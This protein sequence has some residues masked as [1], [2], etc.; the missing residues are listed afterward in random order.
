MRGVDEAVT[1][2][3]LL[4]LRPGSEPASESVDATRF[5][6]KGVGLLRLLQEGWPVPEGFVLSTG[7]CR[8]WLSANGVWPVAVRELVEAGLAGLPTGAWP[9]GT[10][11][12]V[13]SGAGR[14]YP[15]LLRT[16][17]RVGTD[18]DAVLAAIAE[19]CDSVRSWEV[20]QAG[21]WPGS[22][23]PT[24]TA[25]VIQRQIDTDCA[26]VLFTVDPRRP[27][28]LLVEAVPGLGDQ[29]VAG[30]GH[31][32]AWRVERPAVGDTG[33]RDTT[34]STT[35]PS[36]A[37][38]QSPSPGSA[39]AP[40]AA[41]TAVPT[42]A[43][44][45]AAAGE[46]VASRRLAGAE[47]LAAHAVQSP[48][49][50]VGEVLHSFARHT[51][52]ELCQAGLAIERHWGGPVD[53]EWGVA[54]SQLWLFQVR[55]VE[56]LVT[57]TSEPQLEAQVTARLAE[58]G[59]TGRRVWIRHN[60]AESLPNPTPLS[61]D[62][63]QRF[64]RPDGGYGAL[65]RSLGYRPAV[66]GGRS[67]IELLG[68]GVYFSADD[69]PGWFCRGFPL[70]VAVDPQRT[71]APLLET[72]PLEFDPTQLDRWFLVRWPWVA[73]V[74]RRARRRQTDWESTVKSE[75]ARTELPG[76][77]AWLR[78]QSTQDLHQM[79]ARQLHDCFTRSWQAVFGEW[80]PVLLL[81]GTLGVLAWGRVWSELETWLGRERA[82]ATAGRLLTQIPDPT[83]EWQQTLAANF[84][85]GAVREE[86]VR[87]GLGHRAAWE[88]D[89]SVP[90]WGE[91][92]SGEELADR[93]TV[94]QAESDSGG[95]RV[96]AGREAERHGPGGTALE[97]LRRAFREGGASSLSD[98][99]V[100][101]WEVARSLLPYRGLGRHEWTRGL[102]WLRQILVQLG[103][104][105]GLHGDLHFLTLD[106]LAE[107]V[108]PGGRD[109]AA[110]RA[111]IA[112]R[113]RE[114]RAAARLSLPAVMGGQAGTTAP[115]SAKVES[116]GGGLAGGVARAGQTAAGT[117]AQP[118]AAGSQTP[119]GGRAGRGGGN[120]GTALGES[121]SGATA[122]EELAGGDQEP[123][124]VLSG[125]YGEGPPWFY[126][127]GGDLRRCPA[128]A[129]VVARQV[130]A[131]VLPGLGRA[132]GLLLEQGGEL[133]HVA[134]VARSL[135]LPVLVREGSVAWSRSALR[136]VV[137]GERG[138]VRRL[139]GDR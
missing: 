19:V 68:A 105:T 108:Q 59:R 135:G 57:P 47:W 27:A 39:A 9:P 62:L 75:F 37:T 139:G 69:L 84:R 122:G 52:G 136:L 89:L 58:L 31:P 64:F 36:A 46:A 98:A 10:R 22:Q 80:G 63:W 109:L 118:P 8:A 32:C 133:S 115:T 111:R 30:L 113:R 14:S 117:T 55:P 41:S 12:A 51:L 23:I 74:L 33:P 78:R 85:R 42:S 123:A 91:L 97:E 127:P 18:L 130:G 79:T 129:I 49:E 17:L 25:I 107:V 44:R 125:G 61:L 82:R 120:P 87:E 137:D 99:A 53:L 67:L 1:L 119:A 73:W 131:A 65:Y 94:R 132:G 86:I 95:G 90:R 83:T 40:T 4:W 128:G 13:R 2:R 126:E 101:D 11:L 71:E 6:A 138:C 38:P 92:D 96:E 48:A 15:G 70:S 103:E 114:H 110:R 106:E 50:P 112:D 28:E 134:L 66:A 26:G 60:L 93:V 104:R 43:T 7:I 45:P 56:P 24:E 102:A 5:G 121:P 100:R 77:H 21:E 81:P 116:A 124:R 20:K 88:F 72:V 3:D 34:P 29:L 76:W 35:T 54:G 16:C